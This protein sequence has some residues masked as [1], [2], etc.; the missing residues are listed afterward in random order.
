M[1]QAALPQKSQQALRH[2][3]TESCAATLSIV[4]GG[5]SKVQREVLLLGVLLSLMQVLDGVLT[6]FGM[7]TYGTSM[8]GNI[9]LRSLMHTIGY[10]PALFLVKSAS[11]GVIAFLCSQA[12]KVRWLKVAMR[13]VIAIYLVFAVVPWT[14]ILL[15]EYLA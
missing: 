6:G 13:A 15:T 8:E 12:L 1:G 11:I 3:D 2:F 4:E 10:L 14:Y 9:L 5:L 7:A